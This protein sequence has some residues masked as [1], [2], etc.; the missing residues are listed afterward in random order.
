MSN[1]FSLRNRWCTPTSARPGARLPSDP[2]GLVA[3]QLLDGHG[4]C[5]PVPVP[6]RS[7]LRRAPL[8]EALTRF[9]LQKMLDLCSHMCSKFTLSAEYP[10]PALL[11]QLPAARS[12]PWRR[13]LRPVLQGPAAPWLSLP[14]DQSRFLGR[15]RLCL[16]PAT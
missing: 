13:A 6:P 8:C 16:R 10:S 12:S 9:W 3:C 2:P 15:G 14:L 7:G 1:S 5:D 11:C 4:V